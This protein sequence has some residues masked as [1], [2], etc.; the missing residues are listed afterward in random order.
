M[1]TYPVN[2]ID[3]VH[4]LSYNCIEAVSNMTTTN[5]SI[6][7]DV[8]VKKRS[9][10]MLNEMGLNISTAVNV[11]LRQML[12]QGK[13]P[14]EIGVD[15]PT[16]ETKE[17]LEEARRLAADPNVQGYTDVHKMFTDILK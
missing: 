10:A 16:A 9:E 15:I 7:L 5:F 11:F 1:A 4:Y 6:R 3:N 12:R 14:F 8:E 17:A 13:I 2:M